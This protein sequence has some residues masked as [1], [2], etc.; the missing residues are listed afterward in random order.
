[1]LMLICVFASSCQTLVTPCSV[2]GIA[3][4][5]VMHSPVHHFDLNVWWVPSGM[6]T[7]VHPQLDIL[8]P[9]VISCFAVDNIS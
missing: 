6:A 3:Y 1:M 8:N 4:S 5:G 7:S 9:A 2:F